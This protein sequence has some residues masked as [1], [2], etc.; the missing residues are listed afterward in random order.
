MQQVVLG[1]KQ[2]FLF[3]PDYEIPGSHPN[4]SVNT[5]A[6]EQLPTLKQREEDSLRDIFFHCEIGPGEVLYFP[7]R[8]LHATLNRDSYNFFVSL[9]LDTQLMKD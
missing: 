4:I 7:D 9:F 6:K 3:P 1:K 2:W 5:W 8:W